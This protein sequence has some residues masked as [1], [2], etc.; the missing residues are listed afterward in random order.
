MRREKVTE[1]NYEL[2]K[3]GNLYLLVGEIELNLRIVIPKLLGKHFSNPIDEWYKDLP[4]TG[5]EY[6]VLRIALD[7]NVSLHKGNGKLLPKVLPLSFWRNLF[8]EHHYGDLWLPALHRIMGED[9]RAKDLETARAFGKSMD[10]AVR[11]RN[12]ISHFNFKDDERAI[13]VESD[14]KILA[15]LVSMANTRY[16]QAGIPPESKFL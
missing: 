5:S 9:N 16:P 3:M 11:V 4:L 7:K 12:E 15:S 6:G 2:Y 8:K 1:S 10:Q 14:L 13:Q